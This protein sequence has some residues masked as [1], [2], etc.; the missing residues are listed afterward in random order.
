MAKHA[1]KLSDPEETD[2]YEKPFGGLFGDAKIAK[3]VEELIA[4]PDTLYS[5]TDL[6]ELTE[7]TAPTVRAA[8]ESLLAQKLIKKIK[9]DGV[10]PVYKVNKNSKK[11]IALSLLAFAVKDDVDGTDAMDT[12]IHDYCEYFRDEEK[13]EPYVMTAMS[14]ISCITTG[15]PSTGAV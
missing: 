9:D 10:H 2:Y 6:A 12:A 14:W 1:V 8:L 3:V 13:Q 11:F 5:P 15:G 4:D 7:S